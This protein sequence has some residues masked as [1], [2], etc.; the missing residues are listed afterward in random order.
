MNNDFCNKH[1]Y[2]MGSKENIMRMVIKLSEEQGELSEAIL[3][4]L[5]MQSQRKIDAHTVEDTKG[6]LADVIITT[7]VIAR[8]MDIDLEEIL[9]KKLETLNTRIQA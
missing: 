2:V 3:A 1:E 9:V 6:E 7:M 4:G 8:D 5:G